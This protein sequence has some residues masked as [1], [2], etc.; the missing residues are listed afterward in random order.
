MMR[1]AEAVGGSEGLND[2]FVSSEATRLGTYLDTWNPRAE[3]ST[4]N[5]LTQYI[6]F[7]SMLEQSGKQ[8]RI[9]KEKLLDAKSPVVG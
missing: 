4:Y 5:P 1:A 2:C 6:A 7:G 3:D 8:D 9:Q